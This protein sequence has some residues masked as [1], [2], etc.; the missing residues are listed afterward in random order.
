MTLLIELRVSFSISK[1]LEYI[2]DVINFNLILAITHFVQLEP[3]IQFNN[4]NYL[5]F[6][7]FEIAV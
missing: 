2:P 4:A 1:T 7:S 5:Q 6:T 3:I